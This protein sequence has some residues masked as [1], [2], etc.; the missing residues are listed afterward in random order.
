[1]NDLDDIINAY[2]SHSDVQSAMH[3]KSEGE[4]KEE[5]ISES[6]KTYPKVQRELDLHG[7]YSDEA[8]SE[9]RYFISSGINCDIRTVRIITG[10]G[11]HSTGQ[12]S[13]LP[14][15]T[16]R[17]LSSLKKEGKILSFKREKTGGSF[18]AYL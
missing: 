17:E 9:I 16:E 4:F 8:I 13:V 15:A 11:L 6:I 3:E 14:E 2:S 12:K 7:K 18:I 5:D 10:K 1:M